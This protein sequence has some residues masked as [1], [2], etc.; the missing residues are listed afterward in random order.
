MEIVIEHEHVGA[1][2]YCPECGQGYYV[3]NWAELKDGDYLTDCPSCKKIFEI[4]VATTRPYFTTWR[5]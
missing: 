3:K 5:A 4:H 1:D 2:G